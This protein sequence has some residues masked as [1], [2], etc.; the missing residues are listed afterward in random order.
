MKKNMSTADSII[1]ALLALVFLT[2]YFTHSVTGVLGIVLLVLGGIFL[3]TSF[4]RFCP[5]YTL[6]GINTCKSK[7]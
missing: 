2:L 1:R 5:L 6:L 7:K 4:I 3:L